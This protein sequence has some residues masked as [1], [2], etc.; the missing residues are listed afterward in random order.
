M[1]VTV[2]RASHVAAIATELS[3]R[4]NNDEGQQRGKKEEEHM[5]IEEQG[6]GKPLGKTKNQN[7]IVHGVYW[8]LWSQFGWRS[9]SVRSCS[10]GLVCAGLLQNARPIFT[11][12]WFVTN[13]ATLSKKIP[14]KTNKTVVITNLG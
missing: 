10:R 12:T 11:G 4:G 7:Q 13:Q 8:F 6:G 14:S 3:H 2:G 1:V 5:M 9:S